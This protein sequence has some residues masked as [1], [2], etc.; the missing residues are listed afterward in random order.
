V[1]DGAEPGGA[2]VLVEGELLLDQR[3]LVRLV[4]VADVDDHGAEDRVEI[5]V[6]HADV[7][8]KAS[9]AVDVDRQ[10][11]RSEAASFATYGTASP[12]KLTM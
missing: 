7:D 8:R 9:A 3:Y 12:L 4:P 10:H 11:G 6:A 5:D 2:V 1:D